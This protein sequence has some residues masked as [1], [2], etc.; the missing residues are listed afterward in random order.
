MR[1]FILILTILFISGCKKTPEL[2]VGFIYLNELVPS[3]KQDVRYYGVNNFVGKRIEGYYEPTV[4]VT[5]ETAYALREVQFELAENNL[6]LLVFDGY[7]PQQ[8]VDHFVRWAKDLND[9]INKR[10]FYP[11]VPKNKLFELDY[12]A[13]RS[14]HTRGSTID[15]TLID[16]E[17]GKSLD[18]GSNYDFFG[19]VSWP[20]DSTISIKAQEN[21]LKLR[22]V[23]L[24]NG[25]KPYAKEWWHFTLKN[26]P[27]PDTYYNFP[28]K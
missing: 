27:F 15:V 23:M 13:E 16:L 26:E 8:A 11:E 17:T 4:I 10:K 14:G 12:I 9:T 24:D 25:F 1:G 5:K 21:R 19:K 2:E 20:N 22:K 3:I 7:R 6:G 18:M 28:V